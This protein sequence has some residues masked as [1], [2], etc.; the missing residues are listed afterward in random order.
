MAA[1]VKTETR[2]YDLFKGAVA[3]GLLIIIAIL[4]IQ[5]RAPSAEVEP[6][7]V[8]GALPA[9]NAPTIGEEG[10]VGLSGTGPAGAS[11]EIW[12]GGGALA[13]TTVGADGTWSWNGP[14]GPGDHQLS[15]RT[16]DASG[17][18]LNESPAVS[19]NVPEPV[20]VIAVPVINAPTIGEGGSV[21]I[22]GTG[23]PGASVELWAGAVKLGTATIGADGTWSWDGI[24]DPGDHQLSARTVDTSGKTLNESPA[25]SLNV[26]EPVIEI[27]M[28]AISSP[29]IG[30]GG[31]IGLSGTG[32]PGAIVE[33]WAGA[34]KL[35]TAAVGA[36][37]TW[38]WDGILDPGDHQLSARTVDTSG[39]TLN[40]SPAV[41]VAVAAA[42]VPI[43]PVLAEPQ[44]NAGGTVTLTGTAEPGTTVEVLEDGIAVGT[45][46]VQNDGTWAFVYKA[47]A[48]GHQLA[49]RTQADADAISAGVSVEVPAPATTQTGEGQEYIVKQGD[50]LGDLAVRFYG[51]WRLWRMIFD[52]TNTR[53]A[54][55]P[56]FHAIERPGL[57]RPGWKL[58]IPAQ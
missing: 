33:L 19:L 12:D 11:V 44:V 52:A 15:A 21:S 24:L 18:T 2:N 17:K 8:I 36:D 13:T 26:P 37:G 1:N 28:P 22:S 25:V 55:D 9:I 48:G 4:L 43:I 27:A 29:T 30:D 20:I 57:I 50:T 10:S 23:Q 31:R 42:A 40:E 34:V 49:A 54:E 39:K 45:A 56:S 16:V 38:S 46:A 51:S 41:A 47:A 3:V 32:Q 53:A 35:G 58:W 7:A 5:G 14:L 6:T